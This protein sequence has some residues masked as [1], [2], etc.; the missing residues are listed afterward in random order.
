M[1][2][3]VFGGDNTWIEP[4]VT[5]SNDSYDYA[6][7]TAMATHEWLT[8]NDALQSMFIWTLTPISAAAD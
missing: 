7:Y 4:G 1:G 3:S 2:S 8:A 6:F 5:G